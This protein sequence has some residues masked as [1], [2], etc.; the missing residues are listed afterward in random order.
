MVNTN[1]K[2]KNI[3]TLPNVKASHLQHTI[4]AQKTEIRA[5]TFQLPFC[6]TSQKCPPYASTCVTAHGNNEKYKVLP[7][8]RLT[9]V[10]I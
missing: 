6:R 3:I 10:Y 1:L 4:T 9:S 8:Y 7:L 2:N 5:T